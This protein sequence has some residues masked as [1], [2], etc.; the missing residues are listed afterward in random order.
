VSNRTREQIAAAKATYSPT[1]ADL[2]F[3][4]IRTLDKELSGLAGSP[5]WEALCKFFEDQVDKVSFLAVYAGQFDDRG[6]G[7]ACGH[8]RV[9]DFP[10]V[11]KAIFEERDRIE[12]MKNDDQEA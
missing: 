9:L 8:Q 5:G 7:I 3:E 11:V 2:T 12:S 10:V 1:L 6:A 4:E